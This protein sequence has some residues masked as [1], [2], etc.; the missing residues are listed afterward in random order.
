MSL[1]HAKDAR[2]RTDKKQRDS[3][4]LAAALGDWFIP[5]MDGTIKMNNSSLETQGMLIGS[6]FAKIR[7]RK[8]ARCDPPGREYG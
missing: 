2:I 3:F 5:V 1:L 7:D 4:S 8:S 6:T